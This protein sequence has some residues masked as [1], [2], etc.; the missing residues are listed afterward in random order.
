MLKHLCPCCGRHCY[1]DEVQCERGAE[2][3]ETGVIPPRKPR[4]DGNGERKK[5]SEKKMQYLALDRDGKL[6]WNLREMGSTLSENENPN[7]DEL[8]GCLRDED[9]ADLLML[10]E[11]LKHSWHHK[12]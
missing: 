3:K 4:P 5:P 1:L 9:R 12:K 6:L 8:F 2:Y 11:K 10:L 7:T